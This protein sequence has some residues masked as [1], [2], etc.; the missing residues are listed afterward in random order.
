MSC[1]NFCST[2]IMSWQS[3]ITIL[4]APTPIWRGFSNHCKPTYLRMLPFKITEREYSFTVV[5]FIL[6]RWHTR[7][8]FLVYYFSA[9]SRV[10]STAYKHYSFCSIEVSPWLFTHS[11]WVLWKQCGRFNE[12][13]KD[14]G[15]I[16]DMQIIYLFIVSG[17][18]WRTR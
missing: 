5:M 12:S 18:L 17:C 3:L 16:S 4:I 8:E 2:L 11:F 7:Q 6:Y 13:Y 9:M 1:W 15:T 10:R 14:D